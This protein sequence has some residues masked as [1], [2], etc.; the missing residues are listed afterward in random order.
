MG[1]TPFHSSLEDM[2]HLWL[3]NP[4]RAQYGYCAKVTWILKQTDDVSHEIKKV[5]FLAA[6]L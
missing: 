5:F 4:Q 1:G 3:R 2:R 6:Q